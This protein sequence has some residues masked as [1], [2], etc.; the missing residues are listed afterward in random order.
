MRVCACVCTYVRG[1]VLFPRQT[2]DAIEAW[3]ATKEEAPV[4]RDGFERK[5]P[6]TR[7]QD[8]EVSDQ[9]AGALARSGSRIMN[10]RVSKIQMAICWSSAT[11]LVSGPVGAV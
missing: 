10:A 9:S 11:R 7:E 6:L 1:L 4:S 8:E 2:S 5:A 3:M